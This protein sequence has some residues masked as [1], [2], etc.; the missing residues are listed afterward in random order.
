MHERLKD[1]LVLWW[2]EFRLRLHCENKDEQMRRR[3][4]DISPIL[5]GNSF[6]RP[7][8]LDRFRVC[9]DALTEWSAHDEISK[10]RESPTH[11]TKVTV[12]ASGWDLNFEQ[13]RLDRAA[14]VTSKEG[15]FIEFPLRFGVSPRVTIIFVKGYDGTFGDVIISMPELSKREYVARGCCNT[16]NVTQAELLVMNVYQ[17]PAEGNRYHIGNR[18]FG[19]FGVTP[20]TSATM[21]LKF[22]K[23]SGDKFALTFVASC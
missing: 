4:E 19:A 14:W 10:S 8:F 17:Q 20:R 6:S 21:R 16:E 23:G 9:D 13:G 7:E 11:P 1:M 12:N 22:H 2:E 18:R 5:R 3:P 15:S